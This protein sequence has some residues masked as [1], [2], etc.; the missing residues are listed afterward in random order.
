MKTWKMWKQKLHE[1]I[2]QYMEE[3]ESNILPVSAT[4]QL[5]RVQRTEHSTLSF[6]YL[7]E[8]LLEILTEEEQVEY[9]LDYIRE[10]RE[11]KTVYDLKL[12]SI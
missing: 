3:S 1:A 8:C 10:N 12:C 5:K 6:H 9:V 11:T 7:E 2:L 4:Q